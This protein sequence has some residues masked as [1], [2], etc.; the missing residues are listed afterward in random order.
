[1]TTIQEALKYKFQE[2]SPECDRARSLFGKRYFL[3]SLVFGDCELEERT[4]EALKTLD[5]VMLSDDQEKFWYRMM[6]L[7]YAKDQEWEGIAKAIRVEAKKHTY[8]PQSL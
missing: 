4:W 2:I 5:M 8:P 1:M 7:G 3:F 6:R